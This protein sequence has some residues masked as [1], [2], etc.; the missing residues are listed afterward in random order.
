LGQPFVFTDRF[1][2]NVLVANLGSTSFKYKL[3]DLAEGERVLAQGEAERIGQAQSTWAIDAAGGQY[4]GEATLSDHGEAIELHL[5][6]LARC[7]ALAGSHALDAIGFK[8]VHGGPISGAVPV[9][10]QVLSTMQEFADVAPAHNPP[11][12]AAMRSL[13]EK[14]PEVPQVAAFETAFHQTIPKERQAYAVPQQWMD[15]FGIRRYGFHGASHSYIAA[16]MQQV[17]PAA[18]RVISCHL[19]GSSSVCAIEDGQ[20]VATSMGLTPQTGLPQSS[21]VGDFDAFALLKLKSRGID[22]DEALHCLGKE[23]GLKGLS[24]V[25]AD[26]RDIQQAAAQGNEQAQLALDVFVESLRQYI[27]AYLTV[28]GGVDAIV[29]TAGIGQHQPAIRAAAMDGLDF[30]GLKLDRGAN[31]QADGKEE[32]RLEATDSQAQVWTVPT[33]EELIVARQTRHVL[34]RSAN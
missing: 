18:R 16:R 28:L 31:E 23:A 22:T 32:T 21:R 20:S 8:A 1:A 29:F 27:G 25:S 13:G 34:A 14:L 17:A 33:N 12:I 3:F 24:G 9:D 11:Y 4:E 7:G 30:A 26:M 2:M 5:N 19:G 6:E 10:E 15:Q